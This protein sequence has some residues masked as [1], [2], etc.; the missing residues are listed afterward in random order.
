MQVTPAAL[1]AWRRQWGITQST[2]AAALQVNRRTLWGWERSRHPVPDAI[3]AD[4]LRAIA[5]E[6]G[7]PLSHLTHPQ[8]YKPAKRKNAAGKVE[9]YYDYRLTHPHY[10]QLTGQ[11]DFTTLDGDPLDVREVAHLPSGTVVKRDGL[12]WIVP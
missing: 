8:H 6:H 11:E 2:L 1:T 5:R 9:R 3:D 10:W 4:V 12:N 7:A